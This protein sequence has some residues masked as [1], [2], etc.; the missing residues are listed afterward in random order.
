MEHRYGMRLRGFSP[1]C[2]PMKGLLRRE[3]YILEEYYDI[4]VYDRELDQDEL[5]DYELDEVESGTYYAIVYD[6]KHRWFASLDRLDWAIDMLLEDGNED[7]YIG[8]IENGLC[9]KRWYRKD[10]TEN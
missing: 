3:D 10:V 7:A 8:L 9:V 2:Q 4:L 5:D 6:D 1:G